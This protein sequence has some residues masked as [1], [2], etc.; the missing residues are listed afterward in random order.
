MT[1]FDV[2]GSNG[3]V[4]RFT[5]TIGGYSNYQ[6]TLTF[7]SIEHAREVAEALRDGDFTISIR[8]THVTEE[9]V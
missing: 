5:T 9:E 7:G 3:V 6:Y 4:L 2:T 8:S 1:P